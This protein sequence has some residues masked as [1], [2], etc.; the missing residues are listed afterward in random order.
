MEDIIISGKKHK[1]KKEITLDLADEELFKI[2]ED[3]N[4]LKWG[5]IRALT[6]RLDVYGTEILK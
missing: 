4:G 6:Y 3:L 1:K 2:Y 5:I